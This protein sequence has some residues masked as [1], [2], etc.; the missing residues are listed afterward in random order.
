MNTRAVEWGGLHTHV[1]DDLPE[2]ATAELAV[3]LC[4][5]FGAPGTDLVPLAGELLQLAPELAAKAYFVFPEAPLSLDAMGMYGGRA[6]WHL[7]VARITAAVAAGELRDQRGEM[8]EGAVTSREMLLSLVEELAASTGLPS[9]KI[10]L[11][12]FSQGSMLAADVALRMPERP[13]ALCVLSG[14]LLCEDEWRA[15]AGQLGPLPTLQSHG[16]QD[17]I[18]PFQGAE[19]LRDMLTE[20][21]WPVD[22]VAFDG[23][24]TIPVEALSRLAELLKQ[25]C[26]NA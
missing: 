14:T 24:H 8:P 25:A 13:A 11:G 16:H 3:V 18:L 2:G 6:W 26:R 19:W 17:P 22:F 9:S 20:A 21:G 15:L 12:G 23:G 5:G 10:V 7:D 4:H 1:V